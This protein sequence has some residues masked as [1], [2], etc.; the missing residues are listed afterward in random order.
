MKIWKESQQKFGV[1]GLAGDLKKKISEWY[2]FA[3]NSCIFKFKVQ[4]T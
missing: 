2:L 1:L 4:W 3:F